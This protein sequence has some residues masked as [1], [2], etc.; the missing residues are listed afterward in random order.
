M[1]RKKS[2]TKEFFDKLKKQFKAMF[3]IAIP[4]MIGVVLA[5]LIWEWIKFVWSY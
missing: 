3:Y 4:L 5:R 2:K 1:E